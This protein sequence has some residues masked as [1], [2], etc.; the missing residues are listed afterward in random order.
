MIFNLFYELYTRVKKTLSLLNQKVGQSILL[1]EE[2][3]IGLNHWLDLKTMIYLR[4]RQTKL[5]NGLKKSQYIRWF[6]DG[7][8]RYGKCLWEIASIYL[9][10]EEYHPD[11][12]HRKVWREGERSCN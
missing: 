10:K 12:K 2:V 9:K 7:K 8:T 4:K 5:G 11:F 3:V 6:T 1:N